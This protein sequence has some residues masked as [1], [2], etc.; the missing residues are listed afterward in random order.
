MLVSIVTP[1]YNQAQY[2]ERAIRSVFGQDYPRLEYLVVDGG[3]SDGS[4]EI[5]QE[6]EQEI[7]GWISEPDKG[8]ADALNKGF[9]RAEG[10]ILAWLNSDDLYYPGAVSEAVAYLVAHPEVG[11]V[12]ADADYID[13]EGRVIGQFPA[14]QTDYQRMRRGYVHIPQATTFFRREIWDRVGPL[15]L[16]LFFAFDYD[17]WVKIASVSEVKYLPR[18]WAGF[19]LHEEGKSL[20]SAAQCWPDMIEVHR[21]LGGSRFSVIYAKYLLRRLLEPVWM[22]QYKA[23]IRFGHRFYDRQAESGSG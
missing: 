9:A 22:L 18:K 11:M 1:S 4:V 19:R 15:D 2:L 23:R 16:S 13:S 17:L 3:S 10:D 20:Y 5:I 8:H 21:R 6:H 7:D 12:Y 14:A